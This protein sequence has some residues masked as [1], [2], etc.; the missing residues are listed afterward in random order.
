MAA[1]ASRR[2]NNAIARVIQPQEHV[3]LCSMILIRFVST[4]GAQQQERGAAAHECATALPIPAIRPLSKIQVHAS[5]P[6]HLNAGWN[7]YA[8]QSIAR[9]PD[10]KD[11]Q[12]KRHTIH[13]YEY[14]FEE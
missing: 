11:W 14:S 4:I 8:L 7:R 12:H 9:L 13:D 2:A 3:A 10:S 5:K 6:V 1:V